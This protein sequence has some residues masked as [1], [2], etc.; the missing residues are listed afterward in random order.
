M[1]MFPHLDWSQMTDKFAITETNEGQSMPLVALPTID[2]CNEWLDNN[3]YEFSDL[4]VYEWKDFTWVPVIEYT[5]RT[6][7]FKNSKY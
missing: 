4:V 5:R 6:I 2:E 1:T 3:G 7:S